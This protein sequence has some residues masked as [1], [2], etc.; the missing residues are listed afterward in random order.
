MPDGVST[1]ASTVATSLQSLYGKLASFLPQLVGAI[2]ILIIGWL[3]AAGL[4]A[5][6]TRVLRM[7]KIDELAQRFGIEKFNTRVG[8]KVSISA[9]FGWL[10]KWFFLI[11]TFVAAANAL[12][13][14]QVSD[15][16]Y[17]EVFP[18]F[19]NVVIASVILVI[20]F[21]VANFLHEI[22][23]D[24]LRV[25]NFTATATVANIA[26]WAIL[27]F[28]F[29]AAL[30]QLKIASSFMQDLFRAIVYMLA[31]AGGLAFGLGGRDAAKTWLDSFSKNERRM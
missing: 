10:V 3:I 7:I 25:T 11:A 16:L 2:I 29:I 4:G 12:Q 19:G 9:V 6:V 20:G 21:I 5:L 13:L 30:S 1:T 14:T 17:N 26:R 22:V 28:A 23:A 18:Y 24:A 27:I 15:F 31:L 8:K